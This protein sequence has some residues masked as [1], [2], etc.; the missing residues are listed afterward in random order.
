MLSSVVII[1]RQSFL[2]TRT[3]TVSTLICRRITVG[4]VI[5]IAPI[6]SLQSSGIQGSEFDASQANRLPADHDALFGLE[7]FD[8]TV[9]EIE[10]IVEPDSMRDDV[11]R[12]SVAFVCVHVP[13]LAIL[14]S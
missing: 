6:F 5:N 12:E 8:I 4:Q 10:I 7:V 1:D 3:I 14:D 11:R 13:I 2:Q 9:A